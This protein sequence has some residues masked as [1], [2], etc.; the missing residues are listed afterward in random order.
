MTEEPGLS[1]D[2]LRKDH[3]RLAKRVGRLE[4]V[5]EN[6]EQI[7]DMNARLLDRLMGEPETERT[8][9]SSPAQRAAAAI[10]DA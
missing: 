3:A 1:P 4:A 2:D 10:I 8:R 6:V 5:L 9:R 7:R